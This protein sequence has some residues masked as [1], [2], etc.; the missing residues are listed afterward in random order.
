M[1]F[2]D[3]VFSRRSIRSF[4]SK[5]VSDEQVRR[6]IAYGHAAPSGGNLKEWRFIVVRSEQGKQKLANATYRGNSETADPQSWIAT[7]PVV[8]AVAADLSS[9]MRR[10]GRMGL[11]E[12]VYLDCSAAVENMLL[13]AVNLG[14]S[15]CYISGFREHE[16]SEALGLPETMQAIALLPVGYAAADGLARPSVS[17]ESVTFREVYGRP[18][19]E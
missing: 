6:L 18:E 16:M 19:T 14:L 11:N 2:N 17:P 10:Y 3:I 4:T 5:A 13:G 15:S 1:D 12:L 7:A 8:I 9:V